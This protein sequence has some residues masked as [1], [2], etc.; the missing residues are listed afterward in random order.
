MTTEL[1]PQ[2]PTLSEQASIALARNCA[3][4]TFHTLAYKKDLILSEKYAFAH[5]TKISVIAGRF[6]IE[7]YNQA[8]VQK[9]LEEG[10]QKGFLKGFEEIEPD[11]LY[12]SIYTGDLALRFTPFDGGKHETMWFENGQPTTIEELLK[13]YPASQLKYRKPTGERPATMMVY[14]KNIISIQ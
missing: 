10:A 5:I 14:A 2:T 11:F 1:N 3:K 4:G 13:K 6:S 8:S 7:Y 12:R 9:K